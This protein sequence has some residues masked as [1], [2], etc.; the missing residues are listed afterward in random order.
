MTLKN[1]LN[2]RK[3]KYGLTSFLL[4]IALAS[5]LFV[6]SI[7]CDNGY[8]IYYGD[9]NA[10]QIPF[11]QM[12]HDSLWNGDTMWSNTT[13]LGANLIGSYSFYL[14]GSPFF[15]ITMLFPSSA[16]PYLMAPLLILK[17]GCASLT[18]YLYLRRYVNDRRFAVLG[19]LLYAFSGF[20]LY[21][22]FFNHFHEAIIIFPFLLFAIDEYMYNKMK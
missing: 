5:I 10:Q 1:Y 13:D 21:N 6:P 9:F 22:V 7:I 19:G 18:A 2:N 3:H 11:Y 12:V 16:V 17:F 4:G 8:F 14:I 20:S 15:W